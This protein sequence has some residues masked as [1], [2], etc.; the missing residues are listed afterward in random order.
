MGLSILNNIP[1]LEAQN[2]LSITNSKLQSTLFQLSSGSKIN[3]GAD[4]P[5]GLSIANGLQANITALTQSAQNVTDG[6]GLLQTADGAL[7]QVT[8]L[9]NRAVTLATEAGNQGLT[10]GSNGQQVALE[11]EFT[12]IIN[13]IDQ[14]GNNTTYNTN[15]VFT[16]NSMSVFLSDGSAT[17]AN[18]PSGPTIAV[19]MPSLTAGQLGL[20]T[21]AT[22]TL[23][24]TGLPQAGN[25]V[26]IGTQTYTFEA[27]GNATAANEVALGT[28]STTAAQV[29]NT[30]L[31]L[32]AA[33]DG[34]AG[35]GTAYGSGTS[36]NGSAQITSVNGGAA[37]VQA[38]AAGTAGNTI[39]LSAVL[40]AGAGGVTSP[41]SG[42]TAPS[43]T[44]QLGANPSVGINAFGTL[45]LYTAP[46]AG[47]TVTVGGN[48]YT[49]ES[50]TGA[51]AANEVAVDAGGNITNTLTNL[52]NA[53][54]GT[55]TEG[56]ATYGSG[57]TA[58]TGVAVTNAGASLTVTSTTAGTAGNG[59]IAFSTNIASANGAIVNG[60]GDGDLG[61]GTNADT[62]TIGSDI[63]TFVASGNATAQGLVAVNAGSINQTLLN[64]KNA[65]DTG[66]GGSA[67]T[68]GSWNGPNGAATVAVNGNVATVT[69]TIPASATTTPV[70]TFTASGTIA[71]DVGGTSNSTLAGGVNAN[72]VVTLTAPPAV[73]D[74]LT[75]ASQTYTFV[76]AGGATAANEVAIGSGT[77]ANQVMTN[78]LTNLEDAVDSPSTS[79]W[80]ANT[81]GSNTGTNANVS[82]VSPSSTGGTGTFTVQAN[83]QGTGGNSLSIISNLSSGTGGVVGAGTLA[84]G[85]T[86]A[87]LGSTTAAQAA[88]VT[89]ENAIS[90]VAGYRGTI[91]AGINQMTAALDVINNTSQNLTSSLSSIQDANIG[92]VISNMSK[93]QVLEQTGI[94]ALAQSNTSEQAILR[95]LP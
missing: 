57:T 72:A 17:D 58:T 20:G 28:G 37:T 29:Q 38:L 56:T 23:D 33:V 43:G 40:T 44:L 41:L 62:V 61:G 10:Q 15:P 30:L 90:T 48:T 63:Y 49:F 64:L 54:M 18:S 36:P 75:L 68:Y 2:Q 31:N 46:T 13:E 85:A 7:S 95:L 66:T 24:L 35:A 11:N 53:I 19:T 42:G 71:S 81:Y 70:V 3:S 6:V 45:T 39:P 22:G 80:G 65:V 73:G 94:A 82:I 8:T 51:T 78:T 14:I 4:D 67:S 12:S 47:N 76:A 27:A 92:T 74:T 77:T 88:L 21:Y 91:G 5:A 25:T 93:Y 50:A 60:G 83:V 87:S 52:K 89:I 84:G 32:E 34:L 55:G 69:E 1:S 16:G 9:L 26:T 59:Q 79:T 86:S